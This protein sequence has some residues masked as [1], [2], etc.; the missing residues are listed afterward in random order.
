MPGSPRGLLPHPLAFQGRGSGDQGAVRG[1]CSPSQEP[2]CWERCRGDGPSTFP[3][4]P[5][6]SGACSSLSSRLPPSPAVP[7][8]C[9]YRS[10]GAPGGGPQGSVD[11]PCTGPRH[12]GASV[13]ASPRTQIPSSPLGCH[14]TSV[15][16]GVS[17]PSGGGGTVHGKRQMA[18]WRGLAQQT[19]LALCPKWLRPAGLSSP[20]SRPFNVPH[21]SPYCPPSPL[22]QPSPSFYLGQL[23]ILEKRL[24]QHTGGL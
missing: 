24:R 7:G 13:S 1:A 4:L 20:K 22:L 14:L 21:L 5:A 6:V 16:P 17:L 18:G 23:F 9:S 12:S 8:A 10:P 19:T 3:V 15:G 11:P 2:S